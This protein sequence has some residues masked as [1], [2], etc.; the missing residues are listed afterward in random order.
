MLSDFISFIDLFCHGAYSCV[1]SWDSVLSIGLDGD[2]EVCVSRF[3]WFLRRKHLSCR[4]VDFRREEI[5]VNRR[6]TSDGEG[7]S[8][9]ILL[10][11]CF[12]NYGSILVV[13]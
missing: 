6:G 2:D 7:V 4:E 13:T 5:R 8:P 12:W 3:R 11:Y 10:F 9:F 1:E